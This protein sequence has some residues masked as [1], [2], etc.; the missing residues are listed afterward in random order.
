VAGQPRKE[1]PS[2]CATCSRVLRPE[3]DFR[4]EVDAG[5]HMSARGG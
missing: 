2:R 4:L 1:T 3:A 5:A